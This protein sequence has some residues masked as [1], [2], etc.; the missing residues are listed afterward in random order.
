MRSHGTSG[1]AAPHLLHVRSRS[2][3][4]STDMDERASSPSLAGGSRAPTPTISE[5]SMLSPHGV[6]E[7]TF[8]HFTARMVQQYVKE[9]EVRA[10]HQATLLQ[11]REKA[12]KEKTKVRETLCVVKG[13][14]D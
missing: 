13:R 1:Q 11:L 9:E 10:R 6:G 7:D 14:H 4:E 2:R 3:H 5:A 12:L 8:F